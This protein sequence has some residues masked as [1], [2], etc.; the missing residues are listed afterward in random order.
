M[1]SFVEK[2]LGEKLFHFGCLDEQSVNGMD[3]EVFIEKMG[4]ECP[5]RT[6]FAET[7]LLMCLSQ[8]IENRVH[9]FAGI[10]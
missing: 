4:F 8:K 5:K 1:L 2:N 9:L 10:I 7:S 3:A 6:M